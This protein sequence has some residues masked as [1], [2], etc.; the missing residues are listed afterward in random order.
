MTLKFEHILETLL[1]NF[2]FQTLRGVR[3]HSGE[4]SEHPDGHGRVDGVEGI[5]DQSGDG[6][7]P[8]AGA[9]TGPR[10]GTPLLPHRVLH[11]IPTGNEVSKGSRVRI[12]DRTRFFVH[13]FL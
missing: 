13:P 1:Y 5:H 9:E 7:H 8:A 2:Q 6:D 3:A 4:G 10:R 11:R 12:S